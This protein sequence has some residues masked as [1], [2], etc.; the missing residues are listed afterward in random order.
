MRSAIALALAAAIAAGACYSGSSTARPAD[1][2]AG[3]DASI[4][5]DASDA[6]T[7]P[8]V[9]PE[10]MDDGPDAGAC[11]TQF[12]GCAT[13]D[14][15][16]AGDGGALVTFSDFAYAPK[17]LRV[18]VGQTVTFQGDF[19]RH[20]LRQACGPVVVFDDMMGTRTSLTPALAGTYG[21]YCLDHGN[22]NG[23]VMSGAVLVVP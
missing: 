11:H 5:E 3:G 23:D 9:L 20:P 6:A 12:A 17:C 4:A 18:K 21:Y 15:A 22:T 7:D 2:D 16:D 10:A 8:V 19:M 1:A 14:E 13:F